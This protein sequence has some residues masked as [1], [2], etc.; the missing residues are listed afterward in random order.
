MLV[1]IFVSLNL[2]IFGIILTNVN[3]WRLPWFGIMLL[4][5]PVF[6]VLRD[7]LQSR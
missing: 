7:R 3:E 4:E 1:T 6:F 5:V 2:V